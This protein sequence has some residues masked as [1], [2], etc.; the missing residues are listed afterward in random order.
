MEGGIGYGLGAVL[1]DAITLGKGGRIVQSNFHD[2][3]SIR[4]NE[5]PDIAVEIIKS[6]ESPTGVGEP[7]VPPIG[8]AVANAWRKLTNAP[9]RQLPIVSLISS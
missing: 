9:V 6:A 2:Y 1:F 3:R 5:M 4:I 7:G 8:P